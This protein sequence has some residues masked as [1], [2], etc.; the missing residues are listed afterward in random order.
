[1]VEWYKIGFVLEIDKRHFTLPMIDHD[2]GKGNV[3]KAV[4]VTNLTW[5]Y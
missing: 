2:N 5:L 4:A 3:S 1:M